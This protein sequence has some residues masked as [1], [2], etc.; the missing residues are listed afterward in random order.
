MLSTFYQGIGLGVNSLVLSMMRQL[1][2]ILPLAWVFSKIT[3]GLVWWAFPIAEAVALLFNVIL[4]KWVW[5]K[6]ISP[7]EHRQE[8]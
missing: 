1:I 8:A 7:L 2:I 5:S 3:L 4:L 6:R